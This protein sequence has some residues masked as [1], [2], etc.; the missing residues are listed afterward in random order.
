M[1]RLGMIV[2]TTILLSA[3]QPG[4]TDADVASSDRQVPIDPVDP[5][6]PPVVQRAEPY[7]TAPGQPGVV[8]I[9]NT[10]DHDLKVAIR[11]VAETQRCPGAI[12]A[13][14]VSLAPGGVNQTDVA[15]GRKLCFSMGPDLARPLMVGICEA[16]GGDRV[17]LAAYGGCYRQ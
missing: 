3:C 13:Q 4:G 5:E 17:A 14:T 7:T 1:I 8:L 15:E 16:R 2:A 10:F 12:G 9:R 6:F 11:D